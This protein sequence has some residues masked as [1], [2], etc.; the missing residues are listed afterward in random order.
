MFAR[1]KCPSLNE[2][3]AVPSLKFSPASTKVQFY[4]ISKLRGGADS[5]VE[6]W[7]A[8]LEEIVG[9]RD[10]SQAGRLWLRAS[11]TRGPQGRGRFDRIARVH[12]VQ[13]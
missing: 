9:V 2:K 4:P 10:G 1:I 3:S 11:P 8:L 12:F 7:E 5:P 6:G 13:R